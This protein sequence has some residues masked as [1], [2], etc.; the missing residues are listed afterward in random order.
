MQENPD[1]SESHSSSDLD[2]SSCEECECEC[3]GDH[4]SESCEEENSSPE[5]SN[6]PF[7]K[8]VSMKRS[9][10]QGTDEDLS[11]VEEYYLREVE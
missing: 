1:I 11:A 6:C 2:S 4:C 3:E 8:M 9:D 7:N 10:I 5:N